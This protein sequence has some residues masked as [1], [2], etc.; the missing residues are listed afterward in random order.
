MGVERDDGDGVAESILKKFEGVCAA[1]AVMLYLREE[2]AKMTPSF[3][4][5]VADWTKI[6]ENY[7]SRC[8]SSS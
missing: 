4:E 2:T 8:D 1:E 7:G 3:L 6:A 5:L